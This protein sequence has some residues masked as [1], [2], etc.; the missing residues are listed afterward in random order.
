MGIYPDVQ[1][2]LRDGKHFESIVR[3]ARTLLSL[4]S[5]TA[6]NFIEE[7]WGGFYF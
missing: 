1:D 7:I 4:L 3:A 5:T 2:T 6:H